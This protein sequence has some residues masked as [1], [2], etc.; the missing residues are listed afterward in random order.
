[1]QAVLLRPDS[2]VDLRSGETDFSPAADT[3]V[4]TSADLAGS[5]SNGFPSRQSAADMETDPSTFTESAQDPGEELDTRDTSA[6]DRWAYEAIAESRALA[7]A[8]AK[9][10]RD[11]IIN[12]MF[13]RCLPGRPVSGQNLTYGDGT[14]RRP[15][16]FRSNID[17]GLPLP[18][19]GDAQAQMVYICQGGYRP[20]K[21]DPA[22]AD[23]LGVKKV[24]RRRLVVGET[25]EIEDS[26]VEGGKRL[27]YP[28]DCLNGGG[29]GNVSQARTWC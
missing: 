19:S 20:G 25:L 24:D 9:P 4:G 15:K 3:A 12:I 16:S 11:A 28:A 14:P 29:P 27:V 17:E 23:E 22:R 8:A 7:F 5:S 18:A 13:G 26:S 21:F 2:A 1:M 6:H 10:D